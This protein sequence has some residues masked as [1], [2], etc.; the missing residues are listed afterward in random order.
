M[1]T[2]RESDRSESSRG[3][4]Q[5]LVKGGLIAGHGYDFGLRGIVVEGTFSP[6]SVRTRV[7]DHV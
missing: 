4:P 6:W 1:Q 7:R 2:D 5:K 3:G